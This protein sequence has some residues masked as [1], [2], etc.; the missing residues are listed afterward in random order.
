MSIDKSTV[1]LKHFFEIL[2]EN[3]I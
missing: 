1:F 2:W 3:S